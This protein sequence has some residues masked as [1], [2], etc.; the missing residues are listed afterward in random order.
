VDTSGHWKWGQFFYNVSYCVSEITGMQFS[1]KKSYVTI[2]GY[3]NSK[4]IIMNLNGKDGSIA[5]FVT[6][7]PVVV[8]TTTPTFITY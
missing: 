6:I 1:S 7:E 2:L 5:M 4:P 8:P 3:S